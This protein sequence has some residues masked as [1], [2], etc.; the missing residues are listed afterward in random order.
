MR[1]LAL[2]TFSF[3]IQ[4]YVTITFIT[5]RLVKDVSQMPL[6]IAKPTKER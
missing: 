6:L 5:C 1:N 4:L 2:H 3:I